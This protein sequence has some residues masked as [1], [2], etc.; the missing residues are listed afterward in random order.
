MPSITVGYEETLNPQNVLS[1]PPL[2][3]DVILSEQGVVF[4][5]VSLE[6]TQLGSHTTEQC[7]IIMLEITILMGELSQLPRTAKMVSFR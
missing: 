6:F 7:V 2:S 5:P 1:K 4:L 3:Q